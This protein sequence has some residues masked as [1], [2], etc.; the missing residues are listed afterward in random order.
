MLTP[1]AMTMSPGHPFPVIPQFVLTFGVVVKD[2]RTGPVH[3]ATLPIRARLDRFVPIPGSDDLILLEEIVRAN[4]QAFY[5]DR[6]VEGAW[7]FR[8]TRGADLEVDDEAA[9]DLLQAIEEEVKRR[10]GNAPVR[11]EAE[12]SMPAEVR[13]MLLRELRFERRSA[14]ASLGPEDFYELDPPL[15]LTLLR[16][17]AGRLPAAHSFAPFQPRKPFA[18]DR[19]VFDQI[20]QGDILVHHPF[21]DFSATVGRLLEEAAVDPDVVAVKMT[22]YRLGDKS[23]VADALLAAAER[24]KDV[25]VLVEL[26]ARFDEAVNVG[27]VHR[28]EEAGAQVIYG[29]V[30]LKT[31][32]KVALVIRKTPQGLRRYAHISTGNYNASTARF[33]TDLGLFTADPAITADLS[34]LF[35]QLTGSSREPGSSYRR[36]LVAPGTM[37]KGFLERIDREIAHAKAGRGGRIR[38]QLNGLEDPEI[39]AALYRASEGGVEVWLMVRSLCVLRPGVPGVS[40][41]IRVMSL[42]G[43]LLEH[44]RVYHFGNGGAD[45]YLIG[46]ADWRPR[47]LR[48]R[49]EVVTPVSAPALTAR[50]D[51]LLTAMFAEPSAWTLGPDGTWVRGARPSAEHPHLHDRLLA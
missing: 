22:L 48:R 2:V 5:R 47:N 27:W 44:E 50:L 20:D 31:H 16:D 43:R 19:S 10:P 8:I 32:A 23:L 34:D 46:S 39:T 40:D 4:I 15:D 36:L 14:A 28:L 41:R 30:G 49:V 3:F 51:A 38:V 26:K 11:V 13:E 42:L 6:P 17:L 12:R 25:T 1:R 33:Y 9:G 45:E 24:G 21:E 35:N 29:M 7:L 37:L 18:T